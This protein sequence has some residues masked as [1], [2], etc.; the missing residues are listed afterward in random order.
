MLKKFYEKNEVLFAVL[1]IL[2]Y[3]LVLVPI[4]GNYGDE[5][6]WMTLVL[7]L[8]AAGITIFVK[9]NHLEEKYGLNGWPKNTRRFL[10]FIPMWII[11]TGNLWGGVS[12]AHKGTAQLF[13][14]LSMALVG[15]VEEMIFRGFLFK[16]LIPK[17]GIVTA[18]IISSVTFGMGHI[19][20]LLTGQGNLETIMQIIFAVS[21]GF[22][23]TMVFHK[24]G[25]LLPSI[26]AHSLIDVF[27]KYS[28][29]S[30]TADWIN[31]IVTIILSVAY[32]IYLCRLK[33]Q[34]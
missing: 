7:L 14:V 26:A 9:T 3:C 24:S 33:D 16:A 27:S 1:W 34:E 30:P 10:Y 4:R 15:Y 31:V 11:V 13:A 21:L 18:V 8:F 2:V 23:F 28:V 20:N 19:V 12:P 6:I 25:S 17:N 29:D 22:L 32:S 5:S